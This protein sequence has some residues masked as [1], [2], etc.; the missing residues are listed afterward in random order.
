MNLRIKN[1]IG[2]LQTA[3]DGLE[4]FM[5]AGGNP[6]PALL[7]GRARADGN[8][9]GTAMSG[10]NQAERPDKIGRDA[11]AEPA[12]GS[13]PDDNGRTEPGG[14]PPTEVAVLFIGLGPQPRTAAELLA[15]LPEPENAASRRVFYCDAPAFLAQLPPE[16]RAQ[17]PDAWTPLPPEAVNSLLNSA[18][19]TLI[20]R[21][22]LRLFPSFYGPLLAQV[23][24]RALGREP[25]R[26]MGRDGLFGQG[27]LHGETGCSGTADFLGHGRLLG[28]TGETGRT[29]FTAAPPAAA[30]AT[31]TA[32]TTTPANATDAATIALTNA[33][34]AAAP[35]VP[36]SSARV[37]LFHARSGGEQATEKPASRSAAPGPSTGRTRPPAVVLAASE[38][39]LLTREL[40]WAFQSLGLQVLRVEP[41]AALR[42]FPQILRACRPGLFISLNLAG[43]DPFG[44]LFYLLAELGI[45]AAT[46]CVDNPWH[47]LSGLR[48][49]F[50][51]QLHLFVTD[52]SFL[53][54]LHAAGCIRAQHLPLAVFPGLFRPDKRPPLC[55]LVFA[56]RSQFPG[57]DRFFAAVKLEP[58]RLERALHDTA[59]GSPRHFNWW[60]EQLGL[61]PEQLWPGQ[62]VRAAGLGAE[63]CSLAWR[64][65]AVRAGLHS[66]LS[67]RVFG[68]AEWLEQVPEL[69]GRLEPPQDYYT[70]LPQIYAA[71]RIVLSSTSLL[72]PA[73]L[74]QR[75]FDAWAA[76]A[77]CLT[78]NTPGLEIFPPELTAPI[79]WRTPGQIGE[80]AR[81]LLAHPALSAELRAAWQRLLQTEHTYR[82]RAAR[83]LA[84]VG[85]RT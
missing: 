59:A 12:G 81:E 42:C 8:A 48:A 7:A 2:L 25:E 56:G 63:C 78:D 57:R 29:D 80:L 44:E 4:Q 83:I 72:L 39:G 40:E 60:Q 17:I 62:A 18:P 22:A 35:A 30:T 61:T 24:A 13:G 31:Q 11:Q 79:V 75:H 49:P 14:T 71:A 65:A 43:F 54:A 50:W 5:S 73:G 3:P 10:Q 51:K 66:G 41:Q 67:F 26:E 37:G 68:N 38:R 70:A 21:P 19:L 77:V 15:A 20:Y 46:W 9:G 32:A 47:L 69:A 53:P 23:Q 84:T 52:A 82:H 33:T 34:D 27:G 55:D 6:A 64:S 45:P 28:E 1:E 85:C 76:G 74:N 16:Q 36:G 58:A